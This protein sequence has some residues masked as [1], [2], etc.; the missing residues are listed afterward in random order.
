MITDKFTGKEFEDL[1][2]KTGTLFFIFLA[3]TV[4]T[5]E[6]FL[7]LQWFVDTDKNSSR[8]RCDRKDSRVTTFLSSVLVVL[9]VTET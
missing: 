8:S 2:S 4:P 7:F 9:K 5:Y 3:L 6:A 1:K